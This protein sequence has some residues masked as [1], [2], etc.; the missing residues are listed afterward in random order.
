MAK[1][2]ELTHPGVMLKEDFLDGMG[3][4]PATLAKAIGVDRGAVSKILAGERDISA[5][6]SLRLGLF[7]GQSEGFWFNLQKDY[8]LRTAKRDRLALYKKTIR[9]YAVSA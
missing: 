1:M 7:F 5:D 9:P 8:D 6:M 2:I 4:R 3:I